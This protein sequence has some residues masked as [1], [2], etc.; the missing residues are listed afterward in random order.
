MPN[1]NTA[2]YMAVQNFKNMTVTL[3][4]LVELTEEQNTAFT[5]IYLRQKKEIN[6]SNS[7]VYVA[8]I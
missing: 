6:T 2:E 1:I 4:F 3:N 5:A 8:F 7:M